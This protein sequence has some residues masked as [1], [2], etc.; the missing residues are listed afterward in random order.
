MN[1]FSKE[2]TQAVCRDLAELG[3]EMTPADVVESR[4]NALATMRSFMRERGWDV[5]DSDEEFFQF[6]VDAGVF[7]T[8]DLTG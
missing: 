3:I 1:P 4:T 8:D 6:I 7:D 2:H 5:P